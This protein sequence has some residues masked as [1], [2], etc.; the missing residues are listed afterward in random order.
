MGKSSQYRNEYIKY[1]SPSTSVAFANQGRL[2]LQLLSSTTVPLGVLT[3]GCEDQLPSSS[4]CCIAQC[5]AVPWFLWAFP[6]GYLDHLRVYT[7]TNIAVMDSFE[8]TSHV[9]GP[10]SRN[11]ARPSRS[12]GFVVCSSDGPV[13]SVRL[14]NPNPRLL[15]LLHRTSVCNSPAAPEETP[16]S[17]VRASIFTPPVLLKFQPVPRPTGDSENDPG[18]AESVPHQREQSPLLYRPRPE[19][20]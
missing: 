2:T 8:Q 3:L 19:D 17:S 10:S 20:E 16:S 11:A 15:C 18:N 5:R 7:I 1:E 13:C 9:R 6:D 12:L 14:M 4:S